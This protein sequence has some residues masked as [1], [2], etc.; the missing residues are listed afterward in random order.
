MIL[1]A[2]AGKSFS[3]GYGLQA[4]SGVIENDEFKPEM[5]IEI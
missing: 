3:L 2:S 1:P 4:R 5:V